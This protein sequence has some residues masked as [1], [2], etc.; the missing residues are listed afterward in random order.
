MD[1]EWL[2][3][4]NDA[5]RGRDYHAEH[6]EEIA[7]LKSKLAMAKDAIRDIRL[8]I[9]CAGQ[10]VVPTVVAESNKNSAWHIAD[11][12]LAAIESDD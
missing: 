12:A 7:R 4:V 2:Y 11:K 3:S 10:D 1:T 8:L 9:G 6:V 5:T